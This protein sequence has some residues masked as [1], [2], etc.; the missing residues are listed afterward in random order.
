M[1]R[2]ITIAKTPWRADLSS[3]G[4]SYSFP[5][6]LSLR[7]SFEN[8]RSETIT[9][10][11]VKLSSYGP[12][13]VAARGVNVLDVSFLAEPKSFREFKHVPFV[14]YPSLGNSLRF[15]RGKPQKIPALPQKIDVLVAVFNAARFFKVLFWFFA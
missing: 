14:G 7:A 15:V 10:G 3:F 8:N 4:C 11:N 6:E 2:R 13:F 12:R 9:I 1:S 5:C